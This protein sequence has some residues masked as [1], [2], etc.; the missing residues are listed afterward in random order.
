[1]AKK[2]KKFKVQAEVITYCYAIIEAESKEEANEI[3][4]FIE[5]QN[6]LK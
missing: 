3:L 1:M 6:N 4:K 2:L 5:N